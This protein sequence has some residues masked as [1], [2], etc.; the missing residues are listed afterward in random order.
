MST[1]IT[2]E[3]DHICYYCEECDQQFDLSLIHI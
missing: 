2:Y 3:T 1:T